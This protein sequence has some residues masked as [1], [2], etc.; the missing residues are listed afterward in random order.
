MV[1][2]HT[3]AYAWWAHMHRFVCLSVR[4][5]VT[6]PKFRLDKK[7]TGPQFMTGQ[8]VTGPQFMSGVVVQTLWFYCKA[9]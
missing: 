8:K 4:L 9:S 2:E 5:S 3:C 1:F 6:E 7:V